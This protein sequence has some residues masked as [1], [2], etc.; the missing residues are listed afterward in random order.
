MNTFGVQSY[1]MC[2]TNMTMPENEIENEN[3][4]ETDQW[5]NWKR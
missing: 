4:N 5:T 1:R 3:E 2:S